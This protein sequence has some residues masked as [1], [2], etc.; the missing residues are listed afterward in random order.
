MAIYTSECEKSKYV[1]VTKA[2]HTHTHTQIGTQRM[3]S[4]DVVGI[5][6][7]LHQDRVWF[8]HRAYSRVESTIGKRHC[9][10]SS[11][12]RANQCSR[13]RARQRAHGE[14]AHRLARQIY[15]SL[16]SRSSTCGAHFVRRSLQA[17]AQHTARRPRYRGINEI[18][19]FQ[20]VQIESL[21]RP[22]FYPALTSS[23]AR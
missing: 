19:L 3:Q 8:A 4:G 22:A 10:R 12:F 11:S 23:L 21:L 15:S 6:V 14:E 16:H 5:L 20:L 1:I 9:E 13:E 7:L 18:K 17:T 2:T